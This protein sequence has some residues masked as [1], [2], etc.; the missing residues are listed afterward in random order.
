MGCIAPRGNSK[1]A[2]FYERNKT[3][4]SKFREWGLSLRE[5]HTV[6]WE[7]LAADQGP[8]VRESGDHRGWL[9]R[10]D[11]QRRR[12]GNYIMHREVL[13]LWAPAHCPVIGLAFWRMGADRGE[14]VRKTLAPMDMGCPEVSSCRASGSCTCVFSQLTC[15]SA[16]DEA[17]FVK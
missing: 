9:C 5:R 6:R 4:I 8:G 3:N 14:P 13:S 2:L 16:S 1:R 10:V 17:A 15:M 7:R 11:L 12:N